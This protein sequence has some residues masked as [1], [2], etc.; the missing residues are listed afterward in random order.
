MLGCLL[1]YDTNIT[2]EGDDMKKCMFLFILVLLIC[3]TTIGFIGCDDDEDSLV[4][5]VYAAGYTTNSSDIEVPCY[6]IDGI[7]TDL[8]VLDST[9]TG[10]SISIYI[11]GTDIYVAGY[12]RNSSKN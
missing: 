1:K 6:W 4:Q 2:C 12:T 11:S 3:I 7:R 5:V 8:S 10:R 9:R